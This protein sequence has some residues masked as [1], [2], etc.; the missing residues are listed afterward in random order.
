MDQPLVMTL[1]QLITIIASI[2]VPLVT[3]IIFL[4]KRD[5]RKTKENHK[6]VLDLTRSFVEVAKDSTKAIENNTKVL[7][8]IME[9]AISSKRK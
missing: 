6:E 4:W 1:T 5:Q 2:V 8:R 9:T 3:A 7:D